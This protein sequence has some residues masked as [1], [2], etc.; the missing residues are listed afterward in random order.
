LGLDIFPAAATSTYMIFYTSLFTVTQYAFLGRLPA[1]YALWLGATG[2]IAAMIGRFIVGAVV[3]KYKIQSAVIFL[4]ASVTV[5]SVLLMGSVGIWRLV[6]QV[7]AGE[8]L[9]F[10]TPCG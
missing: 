4:A 6:L 1:D 8:Y 2:F 9:G 7:R 10:K 5:A 3:K